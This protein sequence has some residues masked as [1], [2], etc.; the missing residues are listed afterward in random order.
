MSNGKV[1]GTPV[2]LGPAP[3]RSDR[4]G[5]AIRL[6]PVG[7]RDTGQAQEWRGLYGALQ[8]DSPDVPGSP[9]A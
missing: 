7:Q 1:P 5:S 9:P 3:G 2:K 4:L 6:V 8:T